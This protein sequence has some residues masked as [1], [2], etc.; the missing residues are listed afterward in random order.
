LKYKNIDL[1]ADSIKGYS[2]LSTHM[3]LLGSEPDSFVAQ[4]KLAL[5]NHQV[6]LQGLKKL[7]G[8]NAKFDKT[9]AKMS[10]KIDDTLAIKKT[11]YL[12]IFVIHIM[13]FTG[14]LYMTVSLSKAE[15]TFPYVLSTIAMGCATGVL[16]LM[17]IREKGKN[18]F[19]RVFILLEDEDIENYCDLHKRLAKIIDENEDVD[20]KI[21]EEKLQK[22]INSLF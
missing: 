17:L 19:N 18:K 7:K 20:E 21:V 14:L 5:L 10:T 1:T 12:L 4:Q 9:V 22:E 3:H 2:D 13:L 8:L 6:I 15:L 11:P 16:N